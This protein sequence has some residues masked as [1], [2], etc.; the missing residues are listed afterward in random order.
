MVEFPVRVVTPPFQILVQLAAAI[1]EHFSVE[2]VTR[3]HIHKQE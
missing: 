2:G 1:P 3:V